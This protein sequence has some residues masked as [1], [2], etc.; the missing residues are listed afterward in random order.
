MPVNIRLY[1]LVWW[2]GAM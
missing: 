1:S 2:W